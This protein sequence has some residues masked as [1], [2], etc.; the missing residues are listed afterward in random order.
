[1]ASIGQFKM[2]KF[3][4]YTNSKSLSGDNVESLALR[5]K[6][7]A[8]VTDSGGSRGDNRGQSNLNGGKTFKI[9]QNSNWN[10]NADW[11]IKYFGKMYTITHIERIN[12]KRFN[13][14]IN[15]QG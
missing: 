12:E 6:T 7:F 2:V 8:E 10:V 13:W 5:L 14:L 15:A 11:K 4:E 9:R 1:M 3:Y